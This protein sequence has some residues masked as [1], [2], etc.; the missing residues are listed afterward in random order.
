MLNRDIY[1]KECPTRQVLK[2]IADKWTVLVVVSLSQKTMRFSELKKE[3]SGI[4]QK[5]LTQTLRGMER[6]GLLCRKVYP[7][8]PPK[9][10]YTLTDLGASLITMLNQIK[11]W[12]EGNIEQVLAAQE[13]YDAIDK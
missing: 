3:I 13:K 9:V 7:T 4:S 2:R 12:S 11:D 1:N 8:V 6:D 5:M 10:E